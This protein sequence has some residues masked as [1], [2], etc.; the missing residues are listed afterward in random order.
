M[1]ALAAVAYG[2]GATSVAIADLIIETP[3]EVWSDIMTG[4]ADGARSFMEGRCK[5]S[6]D[7]SLISLFAG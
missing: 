2:A 4:K 3:F 5:A 7:Y 1:H 6:G